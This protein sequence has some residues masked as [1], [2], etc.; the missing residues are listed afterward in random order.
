MTVIVEPEV[1]VALLLVVEHF[2]F[3]TMV[4]SRFHI[5]IHWCPEHKM[6]PARFNKDWQYI[7]IHWV[8]HFIKVDQERFTVAQ[9]LADFLHI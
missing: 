7:C 3:K 1:N 4:S 9:E 8:P 6:R 2:D 5:V